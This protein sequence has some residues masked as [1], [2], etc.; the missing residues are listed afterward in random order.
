MPMDAKSCQEWF[1]FG[2]RLTGSGPLDKPDT[3]LIL[4]R[5]GFDLKDQ[6]VF[7]IR[8]NWS[9]HVFLFESGK[10]YTFEIFINAYNLKLNGV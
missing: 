10:F 4:H 7:F 8:I 3:D 9:N 2:L 5:S 1:G 6:M